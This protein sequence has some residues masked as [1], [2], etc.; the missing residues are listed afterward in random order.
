MERA[1]MLFIFLRDKQTSHENSTPRQCKFLQ[2]NNY[3]WSYYYCW[4]DRAT[5]VSSASGMSQ[6]FLTH[7]YAQG[8]WKNDHWARPQHAISK[9]RGMAWWSFD[10]LASDSIVFIC[11][12][13][14]FFN[15]INYWYSVIYFF[16][17]SVFY[18]LEWQRKGVIW[19]FI[20]IKFSLPLFCQRKVKYHMK[21]FFWGECNTAKDYASQFLA[22]A[23]FYTVPE[24]Q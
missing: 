5:Q 14:L 7:S 18:F 24:N 6:L 2:H 11:V 23:L 20:C 4:Y 15:L 8:L 21:Y 17:N 12:S 13:G 9:D 10:F 22:F 19:R 3:F 16:L 1:G